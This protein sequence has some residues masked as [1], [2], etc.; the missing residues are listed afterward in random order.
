MVS[1]KQAA[2][3]ALSEDLRGVVQALSDGSLA[4]RAYCESRLARIRAGEGRLKAWIALDDGRALTLAAAR[5]AERAQGVP[6]GALHGVPVG[7][8]DIFDTDDLPTEMGSPA[9]VGNQPGKNA[10]LVKRILV[11]GGYALGKTATTEFAFMHPAETRNPWNPRHTPGGS[12]SGS[13]AAVAA[14]HVPVAVG[15]QTN[16]SVI[17]PAAFCGVVGFKPSLDSLPI[18]GALP[19]AETLDQ[20][21]VFARTVA[22]TAYFASSLAESGTF[23]PEIEAL[24]R[25]PKIA[26]LPR[27]PWNAAE[28]AAAKHLQM[29]LKR[30]AEAGTELKAVALPDDFDEAHRVHRTIML[31]EGAREHAPR[32]AVHRRV[33]SAA[34]NAAIDEGLAMSHDDYRSALA[35]RAALAVLARDLFEDCDALASLPA[36]GVA[37]ARLDVTGDPSFCTLWTLVGFPALTLPVGLSDGGLPY[38]MQLAGA[39]GGDDRLLRVA[40]WCE[41]VIGFNGSPE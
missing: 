17:R 2:K 13:A 3:P 40:S 29:S 18:Q 37:P 14:G 35:K 19:F 10:E 25:P 32:Q 11:A 12:S 7:V 4:A 20:V 5:D 22:D 31:Y 6:T 39:A 16:G 28:P 21:G 8:K 27:F 34:L 30:L 38:G 36:P 1:G 41:A 15:T 23:A 24:S 26:V 9:F 33:M